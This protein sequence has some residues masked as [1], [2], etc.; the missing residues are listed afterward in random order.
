MLRL[1]LILLYQITPIVL[2]SGMLTDHIKAGP[3]PNTYT[4]HQIQTNQL[5]LD[6]LGNN[7]GLIKLFKIS[8]GVA[9]G[10]VVLFHGLVFLV[11]ILKV[12]KNTD[13]YMKVSEGL[14]GWQEKL[15]KAK[16]KKEKKEKNDREVRKAKEIQA[17]ID[18]IRAE[19]KEREEQEKIQK[20]LH[21]FPEDG[22]KNGGYGPW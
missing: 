21:T 8:I 7:P 17:Q 15:M 16:E 10:G 4:D 3:N 12:T 19:R 14:K 2:A 22:P 11:F 5:Y 9:C 13:K 1:L 20:A 18:K 6:D